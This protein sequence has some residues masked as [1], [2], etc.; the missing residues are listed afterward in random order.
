MCDHTT[1]I[2]C[3]LDDFLK[4]MNHRED[5]RCQFSDAEVLTTAVIAMLYFGGNFEKSKSVLKELGLMRRMLS[6]SR[7]S[8][9]LHRLSDLLEIVFHRLGSILKDLNWESRYLLDSFPVP[10]CD[11]IRINRCRLVRDELYR[12]KI[13]SKRRYFYGLRVQVITTIDGVPIEFCLM[14][15]SLHDLQGFAELPLDNLANS[16]LFADTAYTNYE[17]ED[18]LQEVDQLKMQVPRKANSTKAREPFVED[19]KQ[20]FRK[21]IETVFGE[22][23]KLFPKKIHATTLK[24]FALKISLF[25]FAY[26]IDKAFIQ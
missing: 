18:Y 10:I 5:Q 6:R 7:F 13:Q 24:G 21:Q 25:L 26:Q 8:R 23:S 17:W 14:P 19:Y 4:A 1:A 11:N 2:Y 16:E 22:I 9:R 3:F 20:I 12:G 15:G